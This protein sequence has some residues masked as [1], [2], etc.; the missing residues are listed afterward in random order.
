MTH[1]NDIQAQ[2]SQRLGQRLQARG[3]NLTCP[4]CANA[5]FILAEGFGTEM[6]QS[7]SKTL[8][9]AGI[10]IPTVIAVCDNCGYI[11]RFSAGVLGLISDVGPS[12]SVKSE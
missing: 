9:L 5:G 1:F 3:R 12:P 7:D 11:L 8:R 10:T 2:V 4:V 6:L